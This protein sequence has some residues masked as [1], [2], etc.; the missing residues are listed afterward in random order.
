MEAFTNILTHGA[1][2][3]RTIL[4]HIASLSLSS[5]RA[6][7]IHCTTGNN[8]SGVFIAIIL[9]LLHVPASSIADEYA[10]SEIGLASTR[11][12]VVDRLMKSPV[13]AK[14]G[15]GGRERA[16][17]M[18]GARRESM[19]AMLEMV[20]RKWGGVEGYV[21]M[22]CGIGDEE[23]KRVRDVMTVKTAEEE[24]LSPSED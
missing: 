8:R 21:K 14:A 23:I 1:P 5:P 20:E 18:V 7:F 3:F 11:D 19:L 2:A 6:C 12:E 22:A 17:R 9:S 4:L 13:F 24:I 15:G 10:L 16:E